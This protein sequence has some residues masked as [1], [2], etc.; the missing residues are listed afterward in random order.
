MRE[1][2]HEAR[3]HNPA[4]YSFFTSKSVDK[5]ITAINGV[6]AGHSEIQAYLFDADKWTVTKAKLW[7]AKQKVKVISFDE[8]RWVKE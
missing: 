5:G 1:H 6:R 3:I 8:A 4:N 2:R 7:L